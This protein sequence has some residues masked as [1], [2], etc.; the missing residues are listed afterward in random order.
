[1]SFH[2]KHKQLCGGMVGV[3]GGVVRNVVCCGLWC[4]D[5]CA[6]WQGLWYG[7]ICFGVLRC[8]RV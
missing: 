1:M 8:A 4:C 2:K 6:G 7:A 3:S 5:R